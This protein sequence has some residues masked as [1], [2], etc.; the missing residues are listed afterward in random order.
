[1]ADD[2]LKQAE[3]MLWQLSCDSDEAFSKLRT[4]ADTTKSLLEAA[5]A[6]RTWY[7]FAHALSDA[8][9]RPSY[10]A[11]WDFQDRLSNDQERRLWTSMKHGGALPVVAGLPATKI[12]DGLRAQYAK[13][14]EPVAEPDSYPQPKAKNL[15]SWD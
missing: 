14:D 13:P 6:Y 8:T 9:G 2:L 4:S 10:K 15:P 12:L 7:A 5:Q 3:K 11:R 1:M